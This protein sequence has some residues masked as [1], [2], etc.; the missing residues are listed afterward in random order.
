M[1]TRAKGPNDRSLPRFSLPTT[2]GLMPVHRTITCNNMSPVP[3]YT[4][5]WRERKRIKGSLSKKTK[6]RAMLEPR[7]SR[8]GVRCVKWSYYIMLKEVSMLG[9]KGEYHN[10]SLS[11]NLSLSFLAFEFFFFFNKI[12]IIAFFIIES[13]TKRFERCLIFLTS[14]WTRLTLCDKNTCIQYV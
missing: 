13:I 8:S 5:G 11:H 4:P 3:I 10:S 9:E 1:R 12:W 6:R 14:C 7:T 2:L